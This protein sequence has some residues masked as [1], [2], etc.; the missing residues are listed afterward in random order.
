[1]KLLKNGLIY[2]G[3]GSAA[4]RADI[5]VFNETALRDGESDQ[6][7]SFGIEKVYI[8]GTKVMDGAT[9]DTNALKHTGRVMKN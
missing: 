9:L 4:F 8:N 7:H 6:G 2:D 3:T 1:M 5:T